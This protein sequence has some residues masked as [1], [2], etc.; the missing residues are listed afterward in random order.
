MHILICIKHT[1]Q[2]RL[3]F[4]LF[5]CGAKTMDG[6]HATSGD[7][8]NNGEISLHSKR[9]CLV[10]EQRKTRTE[11]LATQAMVK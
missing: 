5:S 9:F 3:S 4:P 10:L 2:K 7:T 11:T 6:F 1:W 8:N